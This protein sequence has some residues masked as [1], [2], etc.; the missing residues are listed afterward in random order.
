[1]LRLGSLTLMPH[2]RSDRRCLGRKLNFEFVLQRKKKNECSKK[3]KKNQPNLTFCLFF[4]LSIKQAYVSSGSGAFQSFLA[5]LPH[6][7]PSALLYMV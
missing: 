5:V 1:V 2:L 4:A 6:F 3:E 7:F